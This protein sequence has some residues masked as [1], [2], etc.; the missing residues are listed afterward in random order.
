MISPEEGRPEHIVASVFTGLPRSRT[1]WPR[2]FHA[3][4]AS[5]SA[6]GALPWPA[7]PPLGSM[8]GKS[9]PVIWCLCQ[10]SGLL[11]RATQASR[12]RLRWITCQG[13]TEATWTCVAT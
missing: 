4:Q 11:R 5:R 10:G 3:S 8:R 2:M 7:L 13:T 1:R 6:P 12:Y 9:S